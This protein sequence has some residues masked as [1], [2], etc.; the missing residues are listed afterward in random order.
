MNKDIIYSV[1]TSTGKV[2]DQEN[3]KPK[4]SPLPYFWVVMACLFLIITILGFSLHYVLIFSSDQKPYWFDHIHGVIMASW[5]FTFIAQT[6][7]VAKGNLKFHRRLGQ[8]S[9]G[10]AVLVLL[11]IGIVFV[12]PIIT[13]PPPLGDERWD[14]LL[15]HLYGFT[16]FGSF[17]IWGFLVRKKAAAHKRLLF[18][19]TLVIIGAGVD[20]IRFLPWLQDA[21][22]VRFIYLDL[23]MIPLM[24][25]DIFTLKHIHKMTL[26]GCVI[27]IITQIGITNTWGLPAWHR[28]WF[29]RLN[30]F[31]EQAAEVKLSN[32]QI[33]PILGEYG[34]KNWHMTVVRDSGKIFLILPNSPRLEMY[35]TS[36]NKWS[37]R[38]TYWKVIFIKGT[39]GKVQKIINKQPDLTW[40]KQRLDKD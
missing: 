5:L 26:I 7:L 24:F 1:N 29:N 21:L 20:R 34:D 36:E 25:Y 39:D 28:F 9:V 37:L 2:Q 14:M 35:P 10:L 27:I 15:L 12:R 22:Y 13:Y 19:A 18:F 40:E 4:P 16:L 33:D 38:I 11:S 23:L 6:I 31:V 3:T 30:P 17:F 8:L 32:S